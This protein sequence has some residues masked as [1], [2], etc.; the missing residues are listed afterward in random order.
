MTEGWGSLMEVIENILLDL[1][2][3]LGYLWPAVLITLAAV[4]GYYL[5]WRLALK[6]S[7][8]VLPAMVLFLI[9]IEV[10]LEMALFSRE[11]GSRDGIDLQLFGTWG[12]TAVAHAYFIENII[13]FVPFGLLVP[14]AFFSRKYVI[15]GHSGR[16]FQRYL[17]CVAVGFALSCVI[18]L[19]QLV[20]GR[21]F[22]QLDD[23]VT[24]TAGT[25]LGCVLSGLFG[26]FRLQKNI[27][28]SGQRGSVYFSGHSGTPKDPGHDAG[29]HAS[30]TAGCAGGRAGNGRT[31]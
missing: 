13:M 31:E 8:R 16:T 11:P 1:R 7:G 21:G 27:D 28:R 12:M 15:N 20:T 6:K 25:V 4:A 30:G 3:P 2:Q 24:N 22:C 26:K 17:L 18:E 5:V 29:A 23:I 9:Y 10:L 19:V 14:R